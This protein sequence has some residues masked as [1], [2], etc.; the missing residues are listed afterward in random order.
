[1]TPRCEQRSP[2]P[3]GDTRDGVEPGGVVG[4][5]VQGGSWA[6]CRDDAELTASIRLRSSPSSWIR[7]SWNRFRIRRS[8]KVGGGGRR[9]VWTRRRLWCSARHSVAFHLENTSESSVCTI[10]NCAESVAPTSGSTC[11]RSCECVRYQTLAWVVMR[12]PVVARAN[13]VGLP[14]DCRSAPGTTD[15]FGRALAMS[16]RDNGGQPESHGGAGEI[17]SFLVTPWDAAGDLCASDWA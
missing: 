6:G 1:M 10:V 13:G 2:E 5:S 15:G 17:P 9:V 12:A 4:D 3:Q 7:T 8:S 16:L 14:A 11:R